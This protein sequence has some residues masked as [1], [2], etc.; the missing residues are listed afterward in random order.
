MSDYKPIDCELYERYELAI[1]HREMLLVCWRDTD[2]LAHLEKLKPIDL[3]VSDGIEF[4]YALTESGGERA[5][6]LD[7]IIKAQ[8]VC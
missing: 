1:M 3:R 2:G 4:L 8:P 5:L 6:R 7:S